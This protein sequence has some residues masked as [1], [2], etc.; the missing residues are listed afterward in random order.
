MVDNNDKSDININLPIYNTNNNN[1]YNDKSN[2]STNLQKNYSQKKLV[3]I[4]TIFSSN[5]LPYDK[6]K[7][8]TNLPTDNTNNNYC[9][10][11]ESNNI[12]N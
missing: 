5:N 1:G 11:D 10:N 7:V 8:N 9:H 12:T 4:N 3:I 2:D 6:F